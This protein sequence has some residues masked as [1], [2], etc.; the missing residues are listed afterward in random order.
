MLWIA[1]S[2]A[3]IFNVLGRAFTKCWYCRLGRLSCL[4]LNGVIAFTNL[5]GAV[6]G[7]NTCVLQ[8]N[9]RVATKTH[10]TTLASDY[11]AKNPFSRLIFADNEP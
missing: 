10:L 3:L 11:V 2:Q 7:L 9:L 4:S 8:A 5:A 1:P 6:M